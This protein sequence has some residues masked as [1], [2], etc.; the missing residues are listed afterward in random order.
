M[1]MFFPFE[2]KNC[3]KDKW[4]IRYDSENKSHVLQCA[5]CGDIEILE[6]I[7]GNR[8]RKKNATKKDYE[9]KLAGEKRTNKEVIQAREKIN[10]SSKPIS[11]KE[12]EP[13][14]ATQEASIES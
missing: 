11:K 1:K 10:E 4:T 5:N 12:G 13:R 14:E 7:F 2:C 3:R 9:K 6:D 8:R